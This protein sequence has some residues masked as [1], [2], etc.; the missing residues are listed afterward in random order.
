MAAKKEQWLAKGHGEYHDV[1]DEKAFFALMKGCERMICHFHRSNQPCKVM[2]HHLAILAK[3]HIET[4]FCRVRHSLCAP[5][6]TRLAAC[7]SG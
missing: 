5:R 6:A 7:T 2:D 3:R 4:K 1:Q